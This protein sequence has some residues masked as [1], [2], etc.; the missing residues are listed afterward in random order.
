[1]V[2]AIFNGTIIAQSD[3]TVVVENNYYF[4]PDSVD[5]SLFT[6]SSTQ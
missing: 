3:Q 5:R 1:M 4:P 2:T 6:E